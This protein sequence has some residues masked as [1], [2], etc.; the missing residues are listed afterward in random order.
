[1]IRTKQDLEFYLSEDRR[2]YG[3]KK[4]CSLKEWLTNKLFPDRNYE[5]MIC[6]RLLEYHLNSGGGSGKESWL[7]IITE[8]MPN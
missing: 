3:K 7:Y 5:F 4:P 1:M 8:S 2:V 6:L